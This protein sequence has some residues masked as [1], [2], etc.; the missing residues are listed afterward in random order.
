MR[1]VER[2]IIKDNRFEEVCHKSG[3]LYNY[4]L[5]NVRQGIFS[6]SYLKEYEFSTKLNRENQFDF[7]NLPSSISQQVI[8]QVFLAIKGWMGSVKEFEKNSSKLHSKPK[9][10]K[11][12]SGKKQNM[13]VFTTASCRVK[14]D[15]YIHFI[16]N[17]IQPIKTNVEKE[18]LKQV[19]IV[20]QATCYVVEVIYERK[21]QNLN[22]QK[23]NF[24]SID[25][26]LNNLC[27]C[28]NNVNQKFFIVNGKVVKSFNQWFN[29]TKA[30]WMSFVG[31]K[32][33]SKRLKRLICYRNLWINDKIHKISRF[34]IDFCKKNDI[35]TITI[36][37]NKN[38]K[39][40]INLGNK[41]NQKFVEIPFSS[42]IDKIS[43]KAKLVG[44][45]VKI[46]EESYTSKV[47][48]LAFESFEKH[49]IYLGKRKKRGLFQSS[50]N[51]L[52][53]ADING[54]IGIVRKVFG[55]SAVQQIIGSGLAFNPIRVNVL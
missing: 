27:T 38:W 17:I 4:V 32:G 35:G 43:Y 23:D 5:Y 39:Q 10:P 15:G 20:P 24:L 41:N 36:G 37:L 54:S 46:T 7:R 26:G 45:D 22:L 44:I 21:E 11:Y 34:I 13:I 3:L 55:D 47:D 2:H 29:K 28:T 31:D 52:I 33:I 14:Q 25:L 19:R 18:E 48:H 53:N 12:K 50:V 6:N 51:Q 9:L 16:K 8:A 1:L 30:K 49:D 42:L 40:N